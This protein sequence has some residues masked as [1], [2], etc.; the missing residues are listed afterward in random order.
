MAILAGSTAIA[1]GL[2]VAL[3]PSASAATYSGTSP[4]GGYGVAEIS[5]TRSFYACD[6]GNPDGFRV[7]AHLWPDGYNYRWVQDADGSNNGCGTPLQLTL[8]VGT[9]YTIQVCLRDGAGGID[10]YCSDPERGTIL[11]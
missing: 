6:L 5:H 1:I 2:S 9:T 11:T 10:T 3:A 7:V 4:K 8:P